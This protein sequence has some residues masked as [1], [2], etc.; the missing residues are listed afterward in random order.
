MSFRIR[1]AELPRERAVF[2]GFIMGLQHFEH[3]FEP[4]RRLDAAVAEDYL[5]PLLDKLAQTGGEI[6]VAEVAS[7][8]AAGWAVVQEAEDDIYVRAEERR[9][10]YIAELFVVEAARG[11]GM[12]RALIAACMDWARSRGLG[13]IEI[14]VLAGNARARAVYESAGFAPHAMKLRQRL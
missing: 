13:V 7:G 5:Q 14:G 8:A 2:A 10:A 12:G 9:F 3:A 11:S 6:F 4:N 1:T